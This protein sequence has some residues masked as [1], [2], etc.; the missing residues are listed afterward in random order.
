MPSIDSAISPG[1]PVGR[2]MTYDTSSQRNS[3]RRALSDPTRMAVMGHAGREMTDR[4]THATPTSQEAAQAIDAV[5]GTAVD[6]PVDAVG[7]D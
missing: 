2:L 3:P 5:F 7:A 4:Y 6:A 1:C